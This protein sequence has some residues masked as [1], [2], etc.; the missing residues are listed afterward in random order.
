MSI[1]KSIIAVFV[2]LAI[3]GVV[4]YYYNVFGIGTSLKSVSSTSTT[5]PTS[6]IINGSLGNIKGLSNYS[7][8]YK[9]A[10]NIT[11]KY[12]EPINKTIPFTGNSS[13]PSKQTYNQELFST[14]GTSYYDIEYNGMYIPLYYNISEVYFK[15][16]SYFSS[17]IGKT[18]MMEIFDRNNNNTIM[19]PYTVQ[20]E[21]IINSS[22]T[23]P[24]VYWHLTQA[25]GISNST[26]T[27]KLSILSSS[28]LIGIY[29][30]N[31]EILFP[32]N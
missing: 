13:S 6:Q 10:V 20:S 22:A 27:N 8:Q 1:I 19:A 11:K 32:R 16:Q 21:K 30:N 12:N 9:V 28:G 15:N 5:A 31:T 26:A 18:V 4:A 14:Q 2:I 17:L 7:S 29:Y 25:T 23:G 3:V 24:M